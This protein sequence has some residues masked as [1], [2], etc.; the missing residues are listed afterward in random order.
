MM[1]K[2]YP[3][4]MSTETING[5]LITYLESEI[6]CPICEAIYDIGEKMDKA[7]HP[8]FNMKCAKCKGR[9]TVSIPIFGG[10][11]KVWEKDVPNGVERLETT[12][13]NKHN[14]KPYN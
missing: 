14:G 2:I 10:V 9:L 8:M 7:K 11:M 1:V 12:T 5:G 3:S 4:S 6:K 13:K